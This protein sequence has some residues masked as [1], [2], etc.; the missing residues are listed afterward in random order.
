MSLLD[1]VTLAIFFMAGWW[2]GSK[3]TAAIH[4]SILRDLLD[5]LGVT[6]AQLKKVQLRM[7][8]KVGLADP[9]AAAEHKGQE[10]VEI[11]IEKHADTLYVFRKDNDQFLGQGSTPEELVRRM[12]E[13]LRN[14]RLVASKEDGA[15]LIGNSSWEFKTDTHKL[16][17]VDKKDE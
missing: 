15:D 9:E 1:W 5:E 13:K 10:V 11:K 4:R 7:L 6:A 16:S 3:V 12:G 2:A 14:V 8:K 17:R